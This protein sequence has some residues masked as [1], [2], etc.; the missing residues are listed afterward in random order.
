MVIVL[1]EN[2]AS[3]YDTLFAQVESIS[4]LSRG[5]RAPNNPLF[6]DGIQHVCH[7]NAVDIE[8]LDLG[9]RAF[10][11]IVQKTLCGSSRD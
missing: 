6:L 7:Y 8:D 4:V 11:I 10:E 1:S 5:I 3:Q 9:G 2:F